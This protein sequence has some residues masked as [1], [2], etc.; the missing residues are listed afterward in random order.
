MS[1]VH[2]DQAHREGGVGGK[3]PRALQRLGACC[4]SKI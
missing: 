1:D 3:L 2:F 4:R